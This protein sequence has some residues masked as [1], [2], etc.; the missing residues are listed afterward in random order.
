MSPAPVL[1]LASRSPRRASLL[2]EAGIAFEPGPSPNVD[3]TPPTDSSGT[4]LEPEQIVRILATRKAHAAQ[5]LEPEALLL[6][7]DT[8]VFLDGQPLGK[9][10]DAADAVRMLEALSGRWHEVWTGVALLGP[11]ACGATQLLE[12]AVRTRVRFKRLAPQEIEAY[13]ATGEPLDKAG[14]YGIQA[15][16]ADF[17]A[18]LEGP[19]DN[20]IGLPVETLRGLLGRLRS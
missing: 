15:G 11:D 2:T 12:D 4:L 3:E 5:A 13:V 9:P 10:V 7:A 6:T 16:A 17:V 19:L 20:V 18:E 8:L 14:G 1:L